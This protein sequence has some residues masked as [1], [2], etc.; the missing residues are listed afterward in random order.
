MIDADIVVVGGGPAGIAAATTAAECG[1]S[2]LLLDEQPA[3]GGQI[4]RRGV[5]SPSAPD[6]DR[7]MQRL[8]RSGARVEQGVVVADA[9]TIAEGGPF[10]LRASRAGAALTVRADRLVLCTGARE[11]FLPFPGW[12]LPGVVGVGGAQALIKSGMDVSGRRVVI[13]G[14]G[15]L[16]LPVAAMVAG[17]GGH[18]ALVAEQAPWVRV[19]RFVAGLWRR[20]RLLARAAAFRR[21]FATSRYATG[22][23]VTRADGRDRV[24]RVHVTDGRTTWVIPCD[25]LCAGHGLVPETRLAALLGC[26][27]REGAV[28]VDADQRT[29]ITGVFAAGEPTGIGG[30]ELALA[31]GE[32]AGASSGGRPERARSARLAVRREQRSASLMA[33]AFALR[34]ELRTLASPDTILCRCEDVPAGA[35]DPS[36]GFRRARLHCRLG[37]GAC[38]GR[39]CGDALAWLEGWPPEPARAPLVPVSLSV[40]GADSASTPHSAG[41]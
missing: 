9:Y 37:M 21:A 27:M 40:L 8:S 19:A 18:V 20:P 12:T 10:E 35:I 36:G 1:A 29:S 26:A 24:E 34:A 23:W 33:R 7:W 30:G 4:W 5:T 25:L 3:L 15:P 11:R 32:T 31:E 38:Q 39:I 13:A 2:V 41:V 22:R 17:A 28:T 6:A 16:L 14:S